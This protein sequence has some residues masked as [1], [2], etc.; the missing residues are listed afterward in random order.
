MAGFVAQ[1][2]L[3]RPWSDGDEQQLINLAVTKS[4]LQVALQLKRTVAAVSK[5]AIA[6]G[7]KFAL[8]DESGKWRRKRV[9]G[10]PTL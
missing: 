2:R 7:I 1:P 9:P 6:L 8:P 5:R 4:R 10:A 3:N